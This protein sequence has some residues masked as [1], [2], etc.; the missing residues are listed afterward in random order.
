MARY[1]SVGLPVSE[2]AIRPKPRR[3]L[4][5]SISIEANLQ[6][7]SRERDNWWAGVFPPRGSRAELRLGRG[8]IRFIAAAVARRGSCGVK[9]NMSLEINDLAQSSVLGR[10]HHAVPTG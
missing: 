8:C 2:Y 5:S 7:F 6:A 9:T 10:R 3:S 4:S 1:L